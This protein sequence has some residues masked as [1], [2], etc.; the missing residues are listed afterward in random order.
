MRVVVSDTSPIRYLVLIGE[1]GLLEKLYGRILIPYDVYIELQAEH[2][3]EIVRAWMRNLPP[4]VEV[5]PSKQHFLE[6]SGE[7]LVS[8]ALDSGERA[9]IMLALEIKADLIVMDERAGVDEARR[10]GIAVT[11][12]LGILTRGA[13]RGFVS[14]SSSLNKLQ[15]TNFRVRPEIIRQVLLDECNRSK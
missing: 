13:E 7:L 12:T 9:A 2:T 6:A 15:A 8:F 5:I 14:L 4:W 11:G 1:A 3:P 10:L